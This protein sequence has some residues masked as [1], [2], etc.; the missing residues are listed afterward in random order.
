MGNEVIRKLLVVQ[1][2]DGRRLILKKRL[3]KGPMLLATEEKK[4]AE[5][6]RLQE[7][8]SH[9]MKEAMRAADRKNGEVEGVEAKLK[10][11]DGKLNIARSN[12]EYEAIKLEI[13]GQMVDHDL[14]SEEALQQWSI[15][16]ELEK[17]AEEEAGKVAAQEAE[18]G[19][20]RKEWEEEAKE[21]EEELAGLETNR[22]ERTADVPDAWMEVYEKVLTSRGT[23]VVVE[24]VAQYCKG[25]A[26]S[27]SLHDITRA[28][29]GIEVAQCKSCNRIIYAEGL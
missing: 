28:M 17:E 26:M 9:R 22:A 20:G 4:L 15:G 12:K 29:R 13:A 7:D 1:E 10:D 5:H 14:L 16:E 23:P 24:V 18:L 27:I 11:L 2:V 6:R 25:C 8:A 3:A 19:R 21:M